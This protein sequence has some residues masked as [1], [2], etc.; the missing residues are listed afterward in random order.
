MIALIHE[1]ALLGGRLWADTATIA[2]PQSVADA[3]GRIDGLPEN[4]VVRHGATLRAGVLPGTWPL[5]AE[6]I[7]FADESEATA[8]AAVLAA[9]R[10][11]G[12]GDA[13]PEALSEV[14][15]L[16]ELSIDLQAGQARQAIG[17]P[18][19]GQETEYSATQA[20][21]R[22]YL[23]ALQADAS[24]GVTGYP[25]VAAELAA[26]TAAGMA[27]TAQA[28]ATEIVD[29]AATWLAA[30]AAIKEVRRTAKLQI[31]S[32]AT[33]AAIAAV[34]TGLTWPAGA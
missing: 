16:A 6:D 3:A 22:A 18:G 15:R 23:A 12:A 19:Y 20:D 5:T 11:A 24:T 14:I 29:K 26:R 28:V 33:V 27:V 25:F 9:A 4:V 1:G 21:A 13:V 10:A 34:L 7:Q 32:A 31:E 17:T 2:L 30:L 8:R